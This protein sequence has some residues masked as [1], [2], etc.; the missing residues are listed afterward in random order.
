[1]NR[2]EIKARTGLSE[3]AIDQLEGI[4]LTLPLMADL[5][6]ADL[7][8][9]CMEQPEGRMFVAAQAGP[10]HM[11]SAYQNSVVGCYA[12][13]KDEPAVYRAMETKA[14]VR[15]IKAVTQEERTVRQDVV[16]ISDSIGNVIGV[17][18]GERDVS[19]DILKEQKYEEL[20]RLADQRPPAH[21]SAETAARREVH[22]RVKNH[23]Q[24]IASMMNL[25]ARKTEHEEVR[26]AFRENIARVLSIASINELLTSGENGPMPLMPFLE[27]LR[28]NLALLYDKEAFITL[29]LE[30]DELT[31]DPDQATDIAI[32]VNELVSNAY[33]HAF[34]GRDK[35]GIRLILKRGERYSSITVQDD[36][37]G[38]DFHREEEQGL[39]MSLVKMT[40]RDKLGGKLYL[41]SDAGGTSATFD[42]RE[43]AKQNSIY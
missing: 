4:E 10:G 25:Q 15:D 8:I 36:G 9:D 14:P 19:R 6:G 39:G 18:I 31:V 16:P 24:L 7:F 30:G 35:G 12:E 23:L 34:R 33:K 3:A 38:Y 26:Q 20:V 32:V 2:E 37:S 22:H 43:G 29:T 40:I 17:L 1:M 42:F 41:T 13:R 27:K 21:V 11:P 5:A 28:Q